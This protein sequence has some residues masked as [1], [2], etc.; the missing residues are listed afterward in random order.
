MPRD[1][2]KTLPLKEFPKIY[3]IETLAINQK[4]NR[5]ISL[6]IQHQALYSFFHSKIVCSHKLKLFIICH[7]RFINQ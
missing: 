3:F 4:L 5:H 2:I 6:N 1:V 7:A